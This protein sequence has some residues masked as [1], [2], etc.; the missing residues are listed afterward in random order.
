MGD[1][2]DDALGNFL[3][4]LDKFICTY[5][6]EYIPHVHKIILKILNDVYFKEKPSALAMEEI[7]WYL[8]EAFP[9]NT[10][11]LGDMEY[12]CKQELALIEEK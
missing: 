5:G 12:L 8:A 9:K 1:D 10:E 2:D 11:D 3:G 4:L 6:G 7:L